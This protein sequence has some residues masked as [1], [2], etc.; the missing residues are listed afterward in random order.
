MVLITLYSPENDKYEKGKPNKWR[1]SVDLI[2]E[3]KPA[4]SY[5]LY[6]KK[7]D[8]SAAVTRVKKEFEGGDNFKVKFKEVIYSDPHDI[9]D[10][11]GNLKPII[12][13]I[14]NDNRDEKEIYVH[15]SVGTES[16]K[17]VLQNVIKFEKGKLKEV[18]SKSKDNKKKHSI[19]WEVVER[20]GEREKKELLR[21]T[22]SVDDIIPILDIEGGSV[23][24]TGESGAGKTYEVKKIYNKVKEKR[25]KNAE[26][27]IGG[28]V[29]VNC[30]EFASNP[31]LAASA[32][33]GHKKGAYSGANETK[34]GYL[35]SAKNG[36]LFLDEIG[37][38]D[39]R[40]Q[41]LLLKALDE[42]Q[43]YPLG[44]EQLIESKFRLITG[45]NKNLYNEIENGNFR[46]DLLHR[47][48]LVHFTIDPLR[49]ITTKKEWDD[50]ISTVFTN[51]KESIE[52][53]E[54]EKQ[55]VDF[56]KDPLKLYT[57]F[58]LSKE[59]IW[60]GNYRDLRDSLKRLILLSDGK[61]IT[62][63][64]VKKEIEELKFR[65][66]K[67]DKETEQFSYI[68]KYVDRKI[69]YKMDYITKIELEEYIK[70]CTHSK[71]MRTAGKQ[72]YGADININYSDRVT[73]YLKKYD[74]DFENFL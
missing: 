9:I 71:S 25:Q 22:Y 3:L 54:S 64:Q 50:I 14:I 70:I 34:I 33:F 17:R 21:G 72:L 1:P 23:L 46:E 63:E 13:K 5:I 67:W 4:L 60:R 58:A 27:E 69:V 7:H 65:W 32:L 30:A 29:S 61:Y 42:Y 44:S 10:V 49:K 41:A 18:I 74:L 12:K 31:D 47:I 62:A 66:G 55:G 39:L 57:K 8:N 11:A 43:F 19:E 20:G 52:F 28:F 51:I 2:N 73:K 35:E 16:M 36:L 59:A 40:T 68:K 37:E 38:L 45:T 53:K 56:L 48:S 24:I 26:R 15:T 6:Q